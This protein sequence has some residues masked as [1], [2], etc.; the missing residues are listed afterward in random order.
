MDQPKLERLLR[1]IMLLTANTYYTVEELAERME[2]SPRSIYRYLD[3]FKSAGFVIYKESGCIRMEKN[4]LFLKT[5][6]NSFTSA[7]KRPI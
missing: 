1:L 3:T 4:L 7:K 2:T 5:S 6:P